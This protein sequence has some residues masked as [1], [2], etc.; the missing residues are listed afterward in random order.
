MVVGPGLQ[1]D[2]CRLQRPLVDRQEQIGFLGQ[3]DEIGRPQQSAPWM[4][5]AQQGLGAYDMPVG[6][7]L[8]LVVQGEA[9][10]QQRRAQVVFQ[11]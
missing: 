10:L 8:R 2:A 3:Q 7:H 9:M 5:P 4:H 6:V 1:L 11:S